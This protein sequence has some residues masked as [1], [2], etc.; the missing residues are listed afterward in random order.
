MVAMQQDKIAANDQIMALQID[1]NMANS[2]AIS[3]AEEKQALVS[4]WVS[5]LHTAHAR[6]TRPAC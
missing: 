4:S 1:L 5:L 6:L 2:R 3:L